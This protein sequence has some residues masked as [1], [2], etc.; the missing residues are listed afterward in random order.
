MTVF[1]WLFSAA[2]A[3]CASLGQAEPVSVFAAG[4]G[5]YA[6]YRIP[7]IVRSES[8]TLLAFAEAR[9]DGCGDSGV[10]DLVLRRSVD[11]GATWGPMIVAAP[12]ADGTSGNPAPVVDRTTGAIV[13]PFT[14]N[15]ADAHER[16]ILRGEAPARTVWL[17][18]SEDD[19]ATWS[20][21]R[22]ITDQASRPGW[23]WYATGPCHAIQLANGELVVPANHSTSPDYG[24]WHSHLLRSA[25]GGE[26][27][28]IG[29]VQPGFTNESTVAELADGRLYHNMRSYHGR[30]RRSVAWSGDGGA[31]WTEAR[32]DGALI[33][34]VCQGSVLALPGGEGA[35]APVLFVNPASEKRERLTLRYSADGGETW[36]G[37]HVI[38]EGAAAYSDLVLLEA[39][40]VGCLYENGAASAYERISFIRVPLGAVTSTDG[41]ATLGE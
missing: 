4:D 19:G 33:E 32:D 39:S 17:T 24:D 9:R 20:A 15:A 25:D 34:P 26:T 27:W 18:R 12:S 11:D 6:C 1:R 31:T 22:E 29:Y 35:P 28:A 16:D 38:T 41:A 36:T 8:G 14:R 5:G 37:A 3:C 30:N 23:R 7:A 40:Q 10:I 13:M 2:M 21:P